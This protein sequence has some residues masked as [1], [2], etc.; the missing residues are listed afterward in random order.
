ML[1]PTEP[2]HQLLPPCLIISLRFEFCFMTV[3][4]FFSVTQTGFELAISPE[5]SGLVVF[6][7]RGTEY[8]VGKHF[9]RKREALVL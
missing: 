6:L 3:V 8:G 7:L 2:S 5:A 9:L 1:L 4:L